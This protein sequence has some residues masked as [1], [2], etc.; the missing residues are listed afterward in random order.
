MIVIVVRADDSVFETR[1]PSTRLRYTGSI[2][3]LPVMKH[4]QCSSLLVHHY[5]NVFLDSYS[6]CNL[7]RAELDVVDVD[8]QPSQ[9]NRFLSKDTSSSQIGSIPVVSRLPVM[10]SRDH[11]KHPYNNLSLQV[12]VYPRKIA[13]QDVH[14]GPIYGLVPNFPSYTMSTCSPSSRLRP[15][16]RLPPALRHPPRNSPPALAAR[17]H[18]RH[19]LR[20][21]CLHHENGVHQ[22][23]AYATHGC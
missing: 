1:L 4:A 19:D 2:F 22:G 8:S 7:A 16:Q 21:R 11:E 20:Y 5:S 12:F 9:V 13:E 14:N 15:R 3:V 10:I 17:E 23:T 6:V 18:D